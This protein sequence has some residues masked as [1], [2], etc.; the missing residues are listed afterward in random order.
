[1]STS[2][3]RAH[4]VFP[5]VKKVLDSLDRASPGADLLGQLME[6]LLQGT[7]EYAELWDDLRFPA[8][9]INPVGPV[10]PPAVDSII[11]G[12]LFDPAATEVVS[13]IAQMPH[14]W[15]VGSELRPHVHW[16]KTTSAVG[17]VYWQLE[18]RWASIGQA[19]DGAWTTIFVTTPSVSDQNTAD[20][21]AISRLPSIDA[22][23]R[24]LS[25][26][27]VMRLS[28]VGGN[29]ADTYGADARLL[30]FDIHYQIDGFG[31]L[32]EYLK[33]PVGEWP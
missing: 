9:A 3:I 11:G 2:P 14:A 5:E 24:G 21:H 13:I 16:Q 28:R 6:A 7:L 32:Q 19:M 8:S 23:G 30:E 31:S 29:G 20:V 27:L 1:M 18:Y 22:T 12:L 33:S 15:K 25:D 4:R 17:N 10:S 26:M